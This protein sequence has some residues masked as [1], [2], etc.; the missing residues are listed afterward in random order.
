MYKRQDIT[1]PGQIIGIHLDVADISDKESLDKTAADMGSYNLFAYLDLIV[2]IRKI[3]K[4]N[5]SV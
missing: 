5:L 3:F 4:M 2:I 1:G